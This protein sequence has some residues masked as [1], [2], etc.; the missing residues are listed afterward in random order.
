MPIPIVG[1]TGGI[2]SGKSTVSKLLRAQNFS[3][4]DADQLV[5]TIYQQNEVIDEIQ[6]LH[7]ACVVDDKIDFKSLRAAFFSSQ[8]LQAKIE[9]IIYQRMPKAFNL[10][11]QQQDINNQDFI[12][13]DVPLLFEKNLAPLVDLKVCVWCSPQEQVQRLINRDGIDQELSQKILARQ[14][15]INKKRDHSD[16]VILNDSDLNQLESR[17]QSFS[18]DLLL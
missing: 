7:P 15:D 10:A 13:Y 18:S 5:K 4:I 1:L 14:W 8:E 17:V 2:A 11:F 6:S 3:I 9:H 12:I 16:L